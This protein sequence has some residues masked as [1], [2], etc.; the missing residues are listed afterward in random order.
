MIYEHIAMFQCIF[1][2]WG[3]IPKLYQFRIASV[4][5]WL[6]CGIALHIWSFLPDRRIPGSLSLLRRRRITVSDLPQ[7]WKSWELQILFK[8]SLISR[9]AL[10]SQG[11]VPVYCDKSIWNGWCVNVNY[12]LNMISSMKYIYPHGIEFLNLIWTSAMVIFIH[13]DALG[14]IID[15]MNQLNCERCSLTH[16]VSH[17]SLQP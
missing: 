15:I 4:G 12:T 1:Q 14:S 5:D 10:C 13:T 16:H 7:G 17:S 9:F 8:I 11:N 6:K 2:L 3:L